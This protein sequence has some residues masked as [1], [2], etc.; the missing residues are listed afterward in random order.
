MD[1]LLPIWQTLFRI[2]SPLVA[3]V[4]QRYPLWWPTH[5]SFGPSIVNTISL[6]WG[7]FLL[8]ILCSDHV[9]IKKRPR[10]IIL[11]N[12]KNYCTII[13]NC[14]IFWQWYSRGGKLKFWENPLGVRHASK[15]FNVFLASF[16]LHNNTLRKGLL[17]RSIIIKSKRMIKVKK[18][19]ED[20]W[21][22]VW[23]GVITLSL[24]WI[25][26]IIL[27]GS[28]SPSE[29]YLIFLKGVFDHPC[30]I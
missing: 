2:S 5:K 23:I 24:S 7:C 20:I 13:F 19:K 26:L 4:L 11:D 10:S 18:K 22:H 25:P 12:Y 3:T 21:P 8:K 29:G 17:F 14:L 28:L 15:N 9:S 27:M 16:I 30:K 6:F 1:F